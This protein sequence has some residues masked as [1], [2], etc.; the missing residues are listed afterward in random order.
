[1]SNV[2][3][4]RILQMKFDNDNFEKNVKTSLSSLENLNKSLDATEANGGMVKLADGVEHA[5]SKFSALEVVAIGALMRIGSAIADAGMNLAKSL[6]I[7]QVTAG[8]NKYADKTSAVQTIIAATNQTWEAN[9]EAI[10]FTGTQMEFVDEQLQRLNWFSDETSYSFTDMTNNI[11]KFTAN[12]VALTD[13]VEAMQGISTWAAISGGTTNEASRAMYNLSQAMS[14]GAVKLMDWKSIE[15]ANMGTQEFKQTAIDTAIA[16]GT[17]TKS[18]DGL[19][20]TTDGTEVTFKNFNQTLNDNWFTSEVLMQTLEKYGGFSVRMSEI[21]D[22]YGVTAMQFMSG[23]E[24][25]ENGS[26]TATDIIED[27]GMSITETDLIALFDELGSAE[28]ELGRKAFQ[29]AREA[30]TFAEAIDATKDAVST[31]WMN[32]FETIFGN[33][34][35]AKVFWSDFTEWLWEIFASPLENL[36]TLFDGWAEQGGQAR[37]MQ[38]MYNLM[39][40]VTKV[41]DTIKKAFHEIF[42]EKTS[43]DLVNW[44]RKFMILTNNILKAEGA[45]NTLKNIVYILANALKI[46][47]NVITAIKNAFLDVFKNSSVVS[48]TINEIIN[49]FKTLSTALTND[50]KIF[51]NVKRIAQGFFSAIEIGIQIIRAVFHVLKPLTEPL[52]TIGKGLLNLAGNIGGF[53]TGINDA[54]KSSVKFQAVVELV[55]FKVRKLAFF[56]RNLIQTISDFI[57]KIT[58]GAFKNVNSE[59]SEQVHI[60][61]ILKNIAEKLAPIFTKIGSA[62]AKFASYALSSIKNLFGNFS[63]ERVM[64]LLDQ[65]FLAAIFVWVKKFLATNSLTTIAELFKD[66]LGSVSE[67][68]NAFTAKVNA[69][70]IRHIAISVAI[71]A[72]SLVA[73]S[74]VDSDKLVSSLGVMTSLLFEL[75]GVTQLLAGP[76]STGIK[77]ALT[78]ML[79]ASA[80]KTQMK[81]IK[82]FATAIAI[83]AI[84]LKIISTIEPERLASSIAAL[85]IVIFEMV[86]VA[87]I[88][89][90][91]SS[92]MLKGAS[93]MV[94]FALGIVILSA[95]VKIFSKMSWEELAKGMAAFTVIIGSVVG[96]SIALSKTGSSMLKGALGMI[97]FAIGITI[98]AAAFKIFATMEWTDLAKSMVAF[99]GILGTITGMTILLSKFAGKTALFAVGAGLIAFA[100]GVTIIAAAM[101]IFAT[102]DWDEIKRGM[103]A[104]VGALAAITAMTAILSATAGKSSLLAIGAG[105]I[106][107]ALGLAI[108]VPILKGFASMSWSDLIK[109]GAALAGLFAILGLAAV[110]LKPVVPVLAKLAGVLALLGVACVLAGAGFLMLGAGLTLIGASLGVIGSGLVNL[111]TSLVSLIPSIVK[112]IAG[113][114]EGLIQTV[115]RLIGEY[116]P[117]IIQAAVTLIKTIC[118][119][120]IE[121]APTIFETIVQMLDMLI[122]YIPQIVEKLADLIIKVIDSLATKMPEFIQA[123][124]RFFQ[125]MFGAVGELLGGLSLVDLT[126]AIA[127]LAG[128]ALMLAFVGKMGAA[129]IKGAVILAAVIGIIGLIVTGLGALVTYVPEIEA[130]LERGIPVLE[131]IGYALGSFIGNFVGGLMAGMSAGLPEIA[132]NLSLFMTNLQPFIAG[133]S[134]VTPE[135]GASALSIAEAILALTAANLI[136]G[137]ASFLT[138]GASFADLAEQLIPFA[139]TIVEFSN[140]ITSGNVDTEAVE[141]A[142]NA[143]KMIAAFAS[144]IPNSGGVAGFFAGENDLDTFAAKLVPFGEAIVAFSDVVNGKVDEGAVTSAANAGKALAELATNLPNSGGVAGFFAGNNDIDDFAARITPFGQAIA[145][146]SAAVDG[147]VSQTAVESAANSGRAIA[148]LANN[149][150]NSGGV[151][152]FFAGEND[153]DMFAEKIVPFG[154]AIAEFSEA[155]SGKVNKY[156]VV[157]AANAGQALSELANGLANSGGVVEFFTGGNDIDDF[158]TKIKTF[159]TSIADFSA[160]VAGKVSLDDVNDAVAAGQAL[161]DLAG[162]LENSGGVAGFFAGNNDIDTFGTQIAAFGEGIATF[163]EKVSGVNTAKMGT[164]ISQMQQL[165]TALSGFNAS[166]ASSFA[167]ALKDLANT[168]I[169]E[170]TLQFTNADISG[171]IDTF[172]SSVIT[173]IEGTAEKFHTVGVGNIKRFADAIGESNAPSVATTIATNAAVALHNLYSS[174]YEAGV[175]A[176]EGYIQGMYSRSDSV[177]SMGYSLGQRAYN[178][179]KEAVDSNSPSK[180]FTELGGNNAEGFALG[181]RNSF[182]LVEKASSEMGEVSIDTINSIIS[183]IASLIESDMDCNPT[184]R[185]VLDASN[186]QNGMGAIDGMFADRNIQVGMLSGRL[187]SNLGTARTVSADSVNSVT[188][189]PVYNID[190]NVTASPGMDETALADKIAGKMRLEVRKQGAAWA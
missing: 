13:A 187:S 80:F 188:N 149:L 166:A 48:N 151:S 90:K 79:D 169:N 127:E 12:G 99:V 85:S 7:D 156:A 147:K 160:A 81:G 6:S 117:G 104:M 189:N 49:H 105:L 78:G 96:A 26:K 122:E 140:I 60:I 19:I 115:I 134:G 9:A 154:K 27:L 87:N 93:S 72:G 139:N 141:T 84:A 138:G 55:S 8:W 111:I 32:I 44:T 98:L 74:L 70:T 136:E 83:L 61:T 116:A 178:A 46:V 168:G 135:V 15:N 124:F 182:G 101:K 175:W 110:I 177:Y 131:K 35:Q 82:K 161:S 92:K 114:L 103:V 176:M 164:T 143:G 68:L 119:A 39:D 158:G 183:G 159:G 100:L 38:A 20:R 51:D 18:A 50:G 73:L 172:I 30:K 47:V 113:F 69:E 186:I 86:A 180:K 37:F 24:D 120:L 56:F 36:S 109:A 89:S 11:G 157:N 43:T 174:F 10:G 88:L 181:M 1:M 2:I 57:T 102:M 153:I 142:A 52:L 53:V 130:F 5:S 33:Y 162:S 121:A 107:F 126:T 150:P 40:I 185:P 71:L 190:I 118:E 125:A 145:D 184:I 59:L 123:F 67:A 28:Y 42:P 152:G 63:F 179:A 22:E 129:A 137:I 29:A 23:M 58:N 64:E 76:S 3:E 4:N 75:Y 31:S 66:A 170:F 128:A 108:L 171:T 14:V 25:Y 106:T 94:P 146:F 77:N 21:C 91:N 112:I 133:L 34:E 148:E 45:F 95:A 62:I 97:P 155:V 65:G 17:L 167:S 16:L 144:A 173:A 132:T 54:L 163:S 41:I 165:S